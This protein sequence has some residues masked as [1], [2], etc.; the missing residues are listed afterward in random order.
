MTLPFT[1]APDDRFSELLPDASAESSYV[2]AD[3]E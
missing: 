1:S 2:V 3:V